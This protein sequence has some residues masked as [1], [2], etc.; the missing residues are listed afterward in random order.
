[1]VHPRILFLTPKQVLIHNE[2]AQG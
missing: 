2:Q 1:M